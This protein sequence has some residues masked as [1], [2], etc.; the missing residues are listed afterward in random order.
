MY[1]DPSSKSAKLFER[2]QS[3]LPGGNS[4]HTVFFSP[5]PVYAVKGEGAYVI[6]ADGNRYI[7]FN[8]NASASIHGHCHPEITAAMVKQAGK[9]VS[10]GLPTESE[11]VLAEIIC[12]RLPAMDQV[13]FCNSGTEAVMFAIKAARA[14]AGKPKIAKVEGAYHGAYDQAETSMD[15]MPQTWGDAKRPDAVEHSAGTPKGVLSDVVVLP[16]N[17]IEAT[18]AVLDANKTD[19]AGV[20]FD[21][22]VSRM[23]FLAATPEYARFLRD[24]C[25]END[26]V[27]IFDEVMSLRMG[28]NGAQG[29]VGVEPDLTALGKVIGGGLP[30]GAVAGRTKYMDVFNH[31]KGSPRAPHGGTFNANPLTMVAGRIAME[32]LTRDAYA[33]LASLG[34]RAR[35]GIEDAFKANRIDGQA[36]GYGSMVAIMLNSQTYSN[37]REFLPVAASNPHFPAIHR[38]MLNHGVMT[39]ALGALFLSTPMTTAEI[40][41]LIEGFD[42]GLK[43]AKAEG[44]LVE[45]A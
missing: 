5:Y 31:L 34:D 4:R 12:E 14:Y 16:Y 15:P 39:M 43:A 20:L 11:I 8:N 2:A 32:L 17:D 1:P 26:L 36:R 7:D 18:R 41:R 23:A 13:R 28:F 25:T 29:E 30:V 35:A 40:D 38:T 24:Y 19:L 33:H 37:Y 9:L 44:L 6:D 45:A 21:P 10:V 3:V 42:L 22:L 27:L